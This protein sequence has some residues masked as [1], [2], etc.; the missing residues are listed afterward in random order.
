M[1]IEHTISAWEYLKRMEKK[2]PM[3]KTIQKVRRTF[4]WKNQYFELDLFTRLSDLMLLEIEL[5][6]VDD[7]V[8]LP[9]FVNHPHLKEGAWAVRTKGNWLIRGLN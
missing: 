2:D 1:M 5:L 9:P 8:E 3:R 4:L 6:R 7:Q